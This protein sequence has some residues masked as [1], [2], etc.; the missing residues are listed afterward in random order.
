M[1]LNKSES[2]SLPLSGLVLNNIGCYY[3]LKDKQLSGLKYLE[4]AIQNDYQRITFEF[5]AIVPYINLAI[6][7][8]NMHRYD[9]ALQRMTD[10]IEKLKANGGNQ[11]PPNHP[12]ALKAMFFLGEIA[13]P[14]NALALEGVCHFYIGKIYVE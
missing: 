9:E 4:K 1:L 2:S 12:H 13:L 10:G 11:K 6:F 5:A 8:L 14:T 3:L 7:K